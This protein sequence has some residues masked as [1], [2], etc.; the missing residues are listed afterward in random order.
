MSLCTYRGRIIH[1]PRC[2]SNHLMQEQA[3]GTTCIMSICFSQKKYRSI[4]PDRAS[5]RPIS[6]C[7]EL[8]RV[9]RS[10][11]VNDLRRL[12]EL[13]ISH[14]QEVCPDSS[15]QG[16]WSRCR[17]RKLTEIVVY[18]CMLACTIVL[19]THYTQVKTS[20]NDQHKSLPTT[21]LAIILASLPDE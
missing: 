4:S 10:N 5:I 13:A 7:W 9:T 15:A 16:G 18:H 14:Y 8:R 1:I 19:I 2:E 11:Q 21:R 6:R 20:L 3:V 12:K 17:S